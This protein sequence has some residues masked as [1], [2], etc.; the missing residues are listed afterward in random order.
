[1]P[2]FDD[3]PAD[4]RAAWLRL[5]D[6]LVDILGDELLA[7]WAYGSLIGP[8]RPLRAADLDTH[9]VLN[10]HPD[11]ATAQR[12]QEALH[13]DPRVE[14]DAWFITLDDAR[15]A[16]PPPHAFLEGR[17]DTA[18]AVHRAHW[19]T[20][21]VITIHGP[22]PAEVVPPPTW[23]EVL[24]DLDREL[25]HVERHIKEGDTDRYEASYALLNGSRILRSLET[26]DPVLSKREAGIWALASLPGRWHPAL[27]A[28]LRAYDGSA[29][30]DDASLLAAEMGPFVAMV[31]EHLPRT[32]GRS[33]DGPRWSGY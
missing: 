12:I 33:A 8:D 4:A 21:R 1:M 5:R 15:R 9:V 29:T 10:G 19:L 28:A 32:N 16:A 20:G 31:R 25:E 22:Q 7:M 3:L 30:P 27:D 11:A 13:H 23:D 6:E 2:A 18:W 14:F 17:R 24:A 26:R